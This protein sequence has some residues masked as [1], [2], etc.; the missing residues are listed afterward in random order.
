MLQRY[1]NEMQYKNGQE[2][3]MMKN[4]KLLRRDDRNEAEKKLA[5][6]DTHT[7]QIALDSRHTIIE[8]FHTYLPWWTQ[9]ANIAT[10]RNLFWI[11]STF[12]NWIGSSTFFYPL[13]RLLC[14]CLMISGLD[15]SKFNVRHIYSSTPKKN[16]LYIH[17]VHFSQQFVQNVCSVE[18]GIWAT[19]T[20]NTKTWRLCLPIWQQSEK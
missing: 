6:T 15:E 20:T 18:F 7:T 10:M 2:L 16:R 1:A 11:T 14:F 13:V 8:S 9:F 5:R 17:I 19:H 4:C 12:W 3:S